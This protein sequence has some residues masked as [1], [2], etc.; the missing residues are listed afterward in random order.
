[1]GSCA[2]GGNAGTVDPSSDPRNRVESHC[3]G[4]DGLG[5]I[6]EARAEAARTGESKCGSVDRRGV[7]GR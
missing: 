1:M 2:I 3:A 6:G 5:D 4:D 7:V